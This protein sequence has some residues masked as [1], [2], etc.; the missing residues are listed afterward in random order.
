MENETSIPHIISLDII[1]D[2]A[3]A[4]RSNIDDE[5]M[6]TL[7]SSIRSFGVIQPILVKPVGE[8]YEVIAGHR[9]LLASKAIGLLNIPAIVC[10]VDDITSEVMKMH[11]NFCREDVNIVDEAIFLESIMEKLSLTVVQL[12]EK[13]GRSESYVRDRLSMKNLDPLVLNAIWQNQISASAAFWIDKIGDESVRRD[14]LGIAVRSGITSSQAQHWYQQWSMGQ[15]PASP[16]TEIIEDMKTNISVSVKVVKCALCN[17]DIPLVEAI[18][19]YGHKEC[20][21]YAKI[22]HR[23]NSD[24]NSA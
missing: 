20:S 9:R 16:T 6:D 11:E 2:P 24:Q 14:W 5:S 22:Q 8:R 10:N 23:A 21:D 18:L 4:I 1:D 19:L 7:I 13:I 15:L 12:A 3:L 17:L